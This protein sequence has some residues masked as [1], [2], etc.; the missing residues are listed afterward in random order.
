MHLPPRS[1]VLFEDETDLL[2][3]PP[4][5]ATWGKRGVPIPVPI[6]GYNARRVFFGAIAL[7][8]GHRVVQVQNHQRAENFCQFLEFLRWCYRGRYLVLLLD[9]DPCHTAFQS[10]QVADEL[11][12]ELDWLPK[13]APELNGM[14]QLFR[15]G[16]REVS[17]NRQYPD[18]D[19]HADRFTDWMLR[20]SPRQAL[21]KAGILSDHFWLRDCLPHLR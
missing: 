18:V 12:I 5:A 1:V 10:Q 17:A 2:L 6:S 14:D 16:K 19:Q 7:A 21:T 13:R 20:L 15:R 8:T 3:F 11:E 4:L 9:G